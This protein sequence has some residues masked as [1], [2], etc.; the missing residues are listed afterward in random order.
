ML[1]TRRLLVACLAV[2]PLHVALA[3]CGGDDSPSTQPAAGSGGARA[4]AGSPAPGTAGTAPELYG[5]FNVT[6]NPALEETNSPPS[7][8]FVGKLFAGPSPSPMAWVQKMEAGGCKLYTPNVVFCEQPCTGG[9]VCTADDTCTPY[10]MVQTVGTVTLTGLGPSAI[11]MEPKAN[12]YQPPAGTTLPYPPCAAGAEL[13]LSAAGGSYPPFTLSARCIEPLELAEG[14][15]I[16]KGQPIALSWKPGASS[17]KSNVNVLLDL[18]HHGGSK[19][20]IECD[21]PDNGA[22]SIPAPMVDALVELGI[23]GF[24]TVIV[25]RQLD[26]GAADGGPA[27]VFLRLSAPY[28]RTIEIPGLV[29]CNEDTQCP[30]GQRCQADL[31]C[32]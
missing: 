27:H 30:A 5:Y 16:T 21:V 19:G 13:K 25:T 9:A 15:H 32:E 23:S 7:T 24:P 28:H 14:V 8:S 2:L 12:N 17:V 31:K 1:R 3:A 6:L 20:K 10:P 22:L 11:S 26:G 4:A 18:S 29:S